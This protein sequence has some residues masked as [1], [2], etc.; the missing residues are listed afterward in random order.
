MPDARDSSAFGSRW[1]WPRETPFGLIRL[2]LVVAVGYAAGSQV[3]MV[4]IE[5]SGLQGVF[6]I[7]AG[8]TV[9]FLLRLA[10]SY[11]WIVIVA[12]GLTEAGIDLVSGFSWEPAAGFAVANMVEPLVGALIVTQAVDRID[13][14]RIRHVWWYVFGAV[15]VG[16][17]LGA[18]VGAATG[19][20]LGDLDYLSTFGQWWLGD[21][22]GVVLIGSAILVWGSSPDR[23]R[24]TSPW[25]IALLVGAGLL[26]IGVHIRSLPLMFLVLIV[27]VAAGLLVGVRGVA[28]TALLVAVVI[29]VDLAFGVDTLVVGLSQPMGLVIIKLQL[30]VF[31]IAGLVFAAE[32]Y[33]RELATSAAVLA[34]TRAQLAESERRMERQ[35]ALRLQE[36]LLP[37]QPLTYPQVSVAA[38]YEAGSEA[39]LVGGDWY[40]VI[41]LP[42]DRIGITIG[43]VVGHGVEATAAMGR[44]R[45]AVAALAPHTDSPGELLGYLDRYATNTNG[46]R[47]A[48]AAYAILEPDTG[49]LRYAS[50]GH[51]PM[52]VVEADGSARWLMEG[53]SSPILNQGMQQRPEASTILS[54][55]SL[56]V[57]YTDGLIERRGESLDR[58][59]DRLEKVVRGIREQDEADICDLLFREMGVET[60]RADDVV[61][62]VLRYEPSSV[63]AVRGP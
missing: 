4:I 43:D 45:T 36:A 28:M 44:L 50:A 34:T 27:I 24:L 15:L 59:L 8:I 31:G 41:Q 6:F 35:I 19:G 22:L 23:R 53:R 13:L 46:T 17:A 7:P 26:T 5:R 58:G 16:P 47:F 10:K 38:R 21:A 48:T 25:G 18:G 32:T 14:S 11:W 37:G 56:L 55:E 20:L 3:A 60:K 39:L 52:L 40:D 54:P 57:G 1:T 9:A 63:A 29:A 61:V 2:F 51:P 62:V 12:A 49:V 33:E 30:A 42:N